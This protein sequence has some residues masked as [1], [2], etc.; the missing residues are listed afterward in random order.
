MKQD[1]VEAIN[2]LGTVYYAKKSNRRAVNWY[3]KALKLAGAEARV[4]FYLHEPR[5]RLLRP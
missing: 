3:K 4:G 2:N 5:H 1:Y